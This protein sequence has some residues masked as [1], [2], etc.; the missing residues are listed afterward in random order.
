MTNFL[1]IST[2]FALLF[3]SATFC[4]AQLLVSDRGSNQIT[5]YDAV[6]GEFQGILVS[7][8]LATNGGLL[9]PSALSLGPNEELLVASQVGSVLRY[10]LNSGDF[11][12][13]F[14]TNL[15]VP[16]GLLYD[17][18]NDELFVSTL[19]N[20]NSDL[21]LRYR[22]S[23]G[24]LLSEIGQGSGQTGRTSMTFGPDGN[25]YVGSF[26]DET[27]F[28]G[29]VLQFDGETFDLNETFASLVPFQ[30]TDPFLAGSSGMVFR[31]RSE[32]GEFELDVVGLFSS[33]VIR[34]GL[35]TT[36]E[37]LVVDKADPI[38]ST[39]LVFPVSHSRSCRW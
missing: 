8:D 35:V 16:S 31:E 34:F 17:E 18:A 23:T 2:C 28:L 20:F 4:S 32:E 3:T 19:G 36:E 10:D 6:T 12:G 27:F 15:S 22:A 1:R 21:V 38:V 29:S 25:F 30:Q 11:L 5:K 7:S 33:N 26:A 37:G 39:G 13:T 14:A 9:F 24:E